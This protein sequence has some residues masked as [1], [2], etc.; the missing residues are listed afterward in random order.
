[1]GLNRA[2]SRQGGGNISIDPTWVIL[3]DVSRITAEAF[4][5]HGGKI[6]IQTQGLFVSPD[7]KISASSELGVS[8]TVRVDAPESNVISELANLSQDYLDGGGLLGDRCTAGG[9]GAFAV[10]GGPAVPTAPD[11]A[12]A[13]PLVELAGSGLARAR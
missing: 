13:S 5:G 11:E 1:M 10:R 4:E 6:S 2:I 3:Q 12:L 8:G 7:S 9:A